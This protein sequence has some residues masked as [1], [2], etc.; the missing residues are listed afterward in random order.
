MN[1]IF[2]NLLFNRK[3]VFI[4]DYFPQEIQTELFDLIKTAHWVDCG[5]PGRQSTDI[6]SAKVKSYLQ[7]VTIEHAKS[8]TGDSH[9][10]IDCYLWKDTEG[11]AFRQHTD[12]GM[13]KKWEN[14]LQIYITQGPSDTKLG[15][16]FHNSIFNRKPS[17]ELS[18]ANNSGYFIKNSQTILHSVGAVPK[19]KVRYSLCARYEIV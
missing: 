13:F 11:L 7:D 6:K 9:K 16:R 3:I 17:V 18:Y 4:H 5:R 1:L 15:T 2:Y 14:H 12:T 19:G 10:L 8:W